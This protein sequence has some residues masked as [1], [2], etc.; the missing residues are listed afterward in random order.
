MLFLVEHCL[1]LAVHCPFQVFNILFHLYL[2]L[3]F[4]DSG[5]RSC[6]LLFCLKMASENFHDERDHSSP[7]F[8][9]YVV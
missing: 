7:I 8:P 3:C 1:M 4:Y 9:I 2:K 5:I 6:S